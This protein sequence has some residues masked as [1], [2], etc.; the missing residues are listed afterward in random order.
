MSQ[1]KT[2]HLISHRTTMPTID[3]KTST[4]KHEFEGNRVYPDQGYFKVI[5]NSA[6]KAIHSTQIFKENKLNIQKN[7]NKWYISDSSSQIM[8]RQP[9][10][11]ANSTS[12][13]QLLL[14]QMPFQ[15]A[16]F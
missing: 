1:L 12:Q 15:Q 6:G 14:L 2:V 10:I 3:T 5:V 16:T 7:L 11:T 13:S 9:L 4:V 8:K